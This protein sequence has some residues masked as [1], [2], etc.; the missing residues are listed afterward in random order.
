VQSLLIFALVILGVTELLSSLNSLQFV[1]LVV[2]WSV[3]DAVLLFALVFQLARIQN[4]R[5]KSFLSKSLD[6]YSKADFLLCGAIIL[7][8][9]VTLIIALN[10]PPNNI[11]SMTYHMA[12]VVHW[13]Q[14]Q[15]VKFYPTW[16]ERQNHA[17]PLAEFVILH[18]QVLSR[19]DRF[20]NLVQWSAY[21]GSVI[22]ITLLAREI[23][24][25]RRYQLFSGFLVALLPMAILQSTSTQND[26][27]VSFF[28][29]AFAYY[30][31]RF[32]ETK[33]ATHQLLAALALGLALLTKGTSYIFGAA[34]GFVFG[35]GQLWRISREKLT[36]AV[37]HAGRLFL[38]VFLALSLNLG[39]FARNMNLYGHP[40]STA[41]S[42]VTT[43]Q[44]SLSIIYA[45]MIR[46]GAV[47]LTTPVET[48]N[49]AVLEVTTTILGP[50]VNQPQSTFENWSFTL[51]FF[52]NEDYAGNFFHFLFLSGSLIF[53]LIF[54]RKQPWLIKQ[55]TLSFLAALT[56]FSAL[57]KW[58]PWI[59]RL[60]LPLLMY[61]TLF[62]THIL[63]NRKVPKRVLNWIYCVLVLS[64]LPFLLM[65]SMK[66]V[67]PIVEENPINKFEPVK[68]WLQS[69]PQA[70]DK[71]SSYLSPFYGG[72]SVIL[73]DRERLYFM[74]IQDY[75]WPFL[76]AA[77]EINALEPDLIGYYF[78]DG[79]PWEY[80]FW[81]LMN[82]YNTGKAPEVV[83]VGVT[84]IT[85]SLYD[86]KNE[87]PNIIFTTDSMPTDLYNNPDYQEIY[88]HQSGYVRLFQR[89]SSAVED[90][91]SEY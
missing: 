14:N 58:Q 45:N 54:F 66:P 88:Q 62:I 52:L 29:L 6:E 26:L 18:L 69:Y 30:L 71:I 47:Q 11:D 51:D 82:H 91:N 90:G 7:F 46:N 89:K 42:H 33:Q 64:S 12:R 22:L 39:H 34:L 81:I 35:V 19:S 3:I 31:I 24:L 61:G 17:M 78:A 84:N 76:N 5:L 40:L 25:S 73:T 50:L 16:I 49:Q 59:S 32:G 87:W 57:I 55:Y 20:A 79:P 21:L 48:I 72:Q 8:L 65:N 9:F 67:I 15:N 2:L 36:Q 13:I 75:Y 37:H 80:N 86:G 60:Q 43:D 53:V 74:G 56:L 38:I 23:K 28:I 44:I 10:A 63:K 1:W 68:N 70:Y 4:L 85:S 27:V 77:K 41:N 83:H